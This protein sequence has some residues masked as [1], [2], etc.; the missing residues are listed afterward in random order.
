MAN[1]NI[2]INSEITPSFYVEQKPVISTDC[3]SYYEYTVY[4]TDL[5]DIDISLIGDHD[6]E[7]YILNGVSTPFTDSV[8]GITYDT[9]LVVHFI[10]ENSGIPGLFPEATLTITNNTESDSYI[11]SVQ[12]LNDNVKCGANANFQIGANSGA[13]TDVILGDLVNI[14]GNTPISTTIS[15]SFTTVELEIN[16]DFID[17]DTFATATNSNVPSSESVKAYSD[18]TFEP[19]FSKN[20]AFNKNFGTTSGSVAEGDDSRINN[21]QTAFSWGNHSLVGYLTSETDPVFLASQAFNINAGDITNLSNLS[22]INTG[23]QDL[24]PYQLLSE[25]GAANGY[26]ELDAFGFVPASQ[27]PS[28]VDDVLE[29]ADLASFPVTGESGKVYIALDTNLTYRWSGSVY[30]TIG[31]DLALG[32]TSSTAYRGDRGKIAYDHS[33]IVG[34]EN[35]H[36][37][38]FANIAAKPTTIAGYGITDFN[39]LGDARWLQLT[40]G[41]LTGNTH[42]NRGT[43]NGV[44][45]VK[46]TISAI[47]YSGEIV[48]NGGNGNTII[49]SSKG[50]FIEL[51]DLSDVNGLRYYNGSA[52]S[53][54]WNSLN[55]GSGSGLD[56]DLLRGIHWGN[57]DT[58]IIS[59]SPITSGGEITANTGISGAT[60]S[61]SY[62]G[63]TVHAVA[64]AGIQ[65]L[66][67]NTFTGGITFGDP[68]DNDIGRILYR[69]SIDALDFDVNAANRLRINSTGNISIGNTN[70]TYKLDVTGGV[71]GSSSVITGVFTVATLPTGALAVKGAR[72]FVSD[73][74]ATTFN[75]VVVGG[76]ANNVPVFHDGTTWRIG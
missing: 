57:V 61:S 60:R 44:L 23:D 67:P 55:D 20:T 46:R 38:T 41:T 45:G 17:D 34:G 42:V 19:L 11:S 71:R 3:S 33:Q 29:F 26:A 75:S 68:E 4:A 69:H 27:L 52:Y 48:I 64:N 53:T 12:R 1:F 30:V 63:I 72:A 8:T 49:Q 73:A 47:E 2:T 62:N 16:L 25:K 36:N 39:S 9:S 50:S 59:S 31:N 32:E 51:G 18:N 14:T 15:K 54:V 5:D 56:A 35:P 76:G 10:L 37:T 13:D 28:Y 21:G 22:G 40:G 70:N 66:S 7:A 65:L 74:N 58:P 6:S 43:V 24:S